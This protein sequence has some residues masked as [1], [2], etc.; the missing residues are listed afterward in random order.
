MQ[1]TN[2]SDINVFEVVAEISAAKLARSELFIY[3]VQNMKNI[4][5]LAFT[6]YVK[7]PYVNAHTNTSR[8]IMIT[9]RDKEIR[10]IPDARLN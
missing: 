7:W 6:N 2:V 4:L 5:L 3:F 1:I 9:L 10:C 8:M